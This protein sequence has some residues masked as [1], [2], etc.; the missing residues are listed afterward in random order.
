MN[1]A[2]ASDARGRERL[3]ERVA[4]LD[5]PHALATAPA[6]A[7]RAGEAD[8]GGG[9]RHRLRR[10]RA[11]GARHERD[12]RRAHLPLRD[13]LVAEPFHDVGR[14][15]RLRSFSAPCERRVLGEEAVARVDG[16]AAR[17]RRGRDDARDQVALG[18][19]AGRGQTASSASR[20]WSASRSAVE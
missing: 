6:D 5:E 11:V 10:R 9:R 18:G 1:A 14:P 16:L 15:C 3:V 19:R 12:A 13:R 20:T 4:R 2:S 17:R 8:R 7:K